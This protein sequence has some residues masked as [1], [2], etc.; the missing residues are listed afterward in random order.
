MN[1]RREFLQLATGV[2][3]AGMAA[4]AGLSQAPDDSSDEDRFWREIKAKFAID[5]GLLYMNVASTG[6]MP[7]FL[8]ENLM[9]YYRKIQADPDEATVHIRSLAG[10]RAELA[11]L[12]GAG[13]DEIAITNNTTDALGI[14]L[15]GVPLAAGD[16]I[17]TTLHEH[18][19]ATSQMAVLRDRRGVVIN[20]LELPC[21][22]SGTKELVDIF[23]SNIRTGKTK[24]LLF[25]HIPYK[26]GILLPAK[27]ICQVA[28]EAGI[29]SMIDGAH[30]IGML[31]LNLH[32]IGCDFYAGSGHKWLCGPWGTGILYI[33]N[34][35]APDHPL[36]EFWPTTGLYYQEH[37]PRGQYD[38]GDLLQRRAQVNIPAFLAM[39]DEARFYHDIGLDK[40]YRRV[41]AL[42][43][44]LKKKIASQWD[45]TKLVSPDL[46]ELLTGIT[47]FNPFADPSDRS[48]PQA[49]VSRLKDEYKIVIAVVDYKVKRTDKSNRFA[50]RV[51]T[52][53]FHNHPDVDRLFAAIWE[54]YLKIA[55]S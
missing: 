22:P 15:N 40:I 9:R 7:A 33:R 34:S 42:S 21:P 11:A 29:M 55:A 31:P 5:P 18:N 3:A 49:M 14:L 10:A 19:A 25:S 17:L 52:H 1:S 23:K 44:Y 32:D 54:S 46:S 24:L 48:K 30:A 47:C 36:P 4:P 16:E 20:R 41:T 6:S 27:E 51:S 35:A 50:L 2:A 12:F 13:T 43:S 45:S 8:L 37:R 28:R 53:I 38:I 39:T 26:T